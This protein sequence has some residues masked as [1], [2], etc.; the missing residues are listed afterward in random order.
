VTGDLLLTGADVAEQFDVA[1]PHEI[2]APGT[3]AVL[4]DD[5]RSMSRTGSMW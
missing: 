1:D 4:D 5:A 2:T 3:V